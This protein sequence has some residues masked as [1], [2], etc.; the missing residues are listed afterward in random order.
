MVNKYTECPKCGGRKPYLM[1]C[2]DCGYSFLKERSK[3]HI[4]RKDCIPKNCMPVIEAKQK[5][6]IFD[7]GKVV[8]GGGFG[9]GKGKKK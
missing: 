9:V 1:A 3:K 7:T 5:N 2:I 4:E 6:D 8:S